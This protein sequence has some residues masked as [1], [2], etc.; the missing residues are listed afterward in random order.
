MEGLKAQEIGSLR[1]PE[2]FVKYLRNPSVSKEDKE[3]ARDDLAFIN[4]KMMEHIGLDYVYD[5][6]A[7]RVEM[8][9]YPIRRVNGFVFSG[10]V[11]SFDNRYYRKARCVAPLEYRGNYHAEEFLFV[12]KYARRTPKIPITGPY[13]LVDWSYNEY[14]P[15]REDFLF[16]MSR[17]IIRPLLKD[18]EGLGAQVI[19][20]DEPAA[21]THPDEVSLFVEVFNEAVKGIKPKINVH[22]CYSG[23]EYR[24]LFP[25]IADMKATHYALEFA[26][27]DTVELGLDDDKR[28]GY[29]SLKLFKEYGIRREIGLGVVDVHS[30]FIEPPELVRDRILYAVK[31][32][33]DPSLIYVNPDCG[34]RT[35]SRSVAFKKLENMVE[36]IRLAK[37]ALS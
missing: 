16:A 8:Y 30:D 27:R 24:S 29:L 7:R 37:K 17:E 5:G 3:R 20:V 2:W 25:H 18:L 1:K 12:K 31:M 4:I 33:E 13:T 15:S 26:N 14:Y 6:E 22:I 36:G 34:L 19:Q 21:T 32:L 23:D 11:R 10:R 28:R 9:E 35:R